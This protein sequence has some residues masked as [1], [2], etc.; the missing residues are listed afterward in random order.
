MKNRNHI[1]IATTAIIALLMVSDGVCAAHRKGR[2]MTTQEVIARTLFFEDA[3]H[4]ETVADSIWNRGNRNYA[5]FVTAQWQDRAVY[6]VR[7]TMDKGH[8]SCWNSGKLWTVPIKRDR[9]SQR[10]WAIAMEMANDMIRGV[11]VPKSRTTHYAVE[12]VNPWW[13]KRM[14]YLGKVGKHQRWEGV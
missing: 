12:G 7:E 5:D 14:K 13:A 9:A 8:Y 1:S 11:Y 10:A 3:R 4:P 2:D 6:L